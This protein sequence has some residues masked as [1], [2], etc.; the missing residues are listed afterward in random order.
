MTDFAT[1]LAQLE[2]EAS[3]STDRASP[4]DL[5]SF[6]SACERSRP[7]S[8]D[9]EA[10]DRATHAFAAYGALTD[11][12]G[13]EKRAAPRRPRPALPDREVFFTDLRD[14]EGSVDELRA[15]RRRLAWICHPDRQEKTSARRAECLMSE[16]NAQIDAAITRATHGKGRRKAAATPRQKA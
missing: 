10:N 1:I 11:G 4:F 7:A 12:S 6:T 5:S 13:T 14:A 9:D 2:E 15:L 3:A 8:L 16:F